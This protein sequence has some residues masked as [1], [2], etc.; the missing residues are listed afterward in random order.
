MKITKKFIRVEVLDKTT[1]LSISDDFIALVHTTPY[2]TVQKGKMSGACVRR[3]A[4][5]FSDGYVFHTHLENATAFMKSFDTFTE[6]RILFDSDQEGKTLRGETTAP[7]VAY[8]CA[9]NQKFIV[10]ADKVSEGKKSG[11]RNDLFTHEYHIRFLGGMFGTFLLKE[12]L[13]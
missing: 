10:L 3:I 1:T 11:I 12:P 7:D 5:N 4:I 6:C 8:R 13:V 9:I 2:L